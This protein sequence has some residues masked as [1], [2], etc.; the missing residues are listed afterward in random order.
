[1]SYVSTALRQEICIDRI[2]TIHYFEY[3]KN[4]YFKGESH[5]FWEFLCI[6]RGTVEVQADDK[7]FTLGKNDI[8]FH[9]PME[10]HA[11][12]S[13]SETAPNLVVISFESDSPAMQLFRGR[14]L[15]STEKQ[16]V[17]LSQII[18]E[19]RMAF[20]TPLHL[21]SVEQVQL[22]TAAPFG[23]EQ[24]I[25][26]YLEQLLISFVR[27]MDDSADR[28]REKTVSFEKKAQEDVM[29]K[30]LQYFESH[31]CER[32]TIEMVCSENLIGR[33]YLH[34]MFHQKLN[35]G[36]MEYF[37]CMKIQLAKQ[38]IRDGNKNFSQ[39]S[40]YL[41]YNTSNY[42]SKKFKLITGMSP[43]EYA[44]SIKGLSEKVGTVIPGEKSIERI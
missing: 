38:M 23:S 36:V 42:F 43:S 9:K 21:P 33:S 7:V 18:S 22:S 16:R 2:I 12:K 32:L 6:D 1:M 41:S 19:A 11:I 8:I 27:E 17:L 37:N 35:C 29:E 26:I 4:F 5:D 39:I 24:L 15:T 31:I 30:V 14:I 28:R 10:F 40:D 20:S 34:E 44:L 25:K 3:M 13:C